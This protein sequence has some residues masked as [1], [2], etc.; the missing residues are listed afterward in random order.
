MM[1]PGTS[2]LNNITIN[3]VVSRYAFIVVLKASLDGKSFRFARQISQDWLKIY[4]GDLEVAFLLAKAL[5]GEGDKKAALELLKSVCRRDPEYYEALELVAQL[6]AGGSDATLEPLVGLMA[7][8]D[9]EK[10][11]ASMPRWGNEFSSAWK[12]FKEGKLDQALSLSESMLQAHPDYLLAAVLNLRI[13][14]AKGDE[15]N[16]IQKGVTYHKKWAD[17]VAISL[18]LASY[19]MNMGQET[20]A[21]GL[22]HECVGNDAAGQV[23]QRIWGAGHAY[24]PL[25]VDNF[26][27]RFAY[28]IPA[29]VAELLGWNQ[30]PSGQTAKAAAHAAAETTAA[31]TNETGASTTSGSAVQTASVEESLGESLR[32]VEEAFTNIARQF[33]NSTVNREEGRYPIY[34]VMSCRGGLVKQYGEQT[35]L[36]IENDMKLL[37][38]AVSNRQGW[39]GRVF[40]VDDPNIRTELNITPVDAIDPWKIKLAIKD[41]DTALARKGEMIGALVI[42]GGPDVVPFHKLPNPTDDTDADVP[43]DNPYATLDSN[44]FVPEWPVGRLPGEAGQDAAL[45]LAQIHRLTNYHNQ[46][47]R[48]TTAPNLLEIFFRLLD[49]FRKKASKAKKKTRKGSSGNFGI[50]AAVWRKASSNVFSP[51]GSSSDLMISPPDQSGT[52]PAQRVLSANLAYCNLH[53]VTDAPDWYGQRDSQESPAGPD[54]PIAISPQDLPSNGQAPQVVFSEACYGAYIFNK[55]EDESMALKFMGIGS[56]VMVGSTTVAYGSVD[57]PLIGADLLANL[58][59]KNIKSGST[60]G[61]ALMRAKIEL[62]REMNTRQGFLDGEDQKTLLSFVFFGDPLASVTDN[63]KLRKSYRPMQQLTVKTV[64]DHKSEDAVDTPVADYVLKEVKDLVTPYLPGL[65]EVE[66]VVSPQYDPLEQLV[67]AGG[68]TKAKKSADG[69]VVITFSKSVRTTSRIHRHYARA[70]VNPDG[71]MVKLAVSR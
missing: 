6:S 61:E 58:F 19:K 17:C 3:Q 68:E 2:K 57:A 7:L 24:S 56:Q 23:A 42:V 39:G 15:I 29:A 20:E 9:L 48:L 5:M 18:L 33:N 28:A 53:G 27:F 70:T 10:P 35:S 14:A 64:C 66:V 67:G 8:A 52:Y 25:W 30:L 31:V 71:K 1:N 37:A 55:K 22:L 51:I 62:A 11:P 69:H 65:E 47:R 63:K 26:D 43:S 45:L 60:A 36:V 38:T 50:T 4:P 13:L 34:V 44:Y 40:I 12:T 46:N 59:W 49:L 21:V 54:Y 16:I 41:L 32:S